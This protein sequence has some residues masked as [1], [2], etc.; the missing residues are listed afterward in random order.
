MSIS[1]TG[2]HLIE[3]QNFHIDLNAVIHS[4]NMGQ[5]C[6]FPATLFQ[7]LKKA[8]LLDPPPGNCL[9]TMKGPVIDSLLYLVVHHSFS[10]PLL[11]YTACYCS[12]DIT[13]AAVN[14]LQFSQRDIQY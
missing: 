4:A 12:N 3:S 8:H 7:H 2:N 13:L 1:R 11:Y 10:P 6:L 9:T 14:L 5:F